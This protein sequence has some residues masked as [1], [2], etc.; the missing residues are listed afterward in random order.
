MSKYVRWQLLLTLLGVILVAALLYTI[1]QGK[2]L[3]VLPTSTPRP[4]PSPA[5]TVV[6]MRGGAY[7]EGVVGYAQLINPLFSLFNDVD[8]D[9]CA[10]I[11]EGLTVVSE[12]GEIE[13]RLAERW[14]V[15]DDGRIYT[16]YLRDDVRW[17]DGEPFTAA[18]VAF[19]IGLLQSPDFPVSH[20]YANLWRSVAV[21][22]VD[23]HTVR[24]VL[25]EPYAPFI[26]Y[27]T[28]GLIPQH[29]LGTVPVA[30]LL[31]HP[32]N[33]APVGT[34]LFRLVELDQAHALLETNPHHSLWRETMLDRVELRFYN[35]DADVLAAYQSGEV[36]GIGR[37]LLQDMDR[38][39]AE[40]D[41]QLYSARQS[42]YGLIFFNLQSVDKPFLQ[43][44]RV[45]QA[46]AYALDR[47]SLIDAA[48][49]GQGAAIYSPIM[50][51]SWA[52]KADV[53]RYDRDLG[54]AASLLDQA[55]YTLPDSTRV[56]VGDV[57]SQQ[58]AVRAK[59]GQLLEFTLLTDTASEHVA[60]ANALATQWAAAGARVLI[61]SVDLSTLAVAHLQPR[62]FDAV[63]LEWAWQLDPDPYPLWHETQIESPGQNYSGFENRDAS[64]AIEV[65]RQLTDR[66]QRK[67]LYDLFQDIFDQEVP[68]IL[69]YQ[70]IYTFGVDKQVRDV[71]ISPLFDPSDRFRNI[72]QW[73]PLEKEVLLRDLNDQV[74]DTLDR[75]LD[76]W[77]DSGR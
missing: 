6:Q 26:D 65:A 72:W 58:A 47:Q 5:V 23:P 64:E 75:Q 31:T 30:G 74:D 50:P 51:Q 71:Q 38:A 10:L 35:T 24:F 28:L 53:E 61:Q 63:L 48:L 3:T 9:L 59:N 57:G 37:I 73:A 42:G 22:V 27:T 46:L 69:L 43:D 7:V 77:Y 8:R 17:Q 29:I 11:F 55:G 67:P 66:S 2:E 45:R 62:R 25:N 68:A 40:P 15:S 13:P 19:T 12:R 32:F 56:R 4:S 36:M 21:E 18:D 1:S 76:L 14:S 41:L 44:R 33:V 49:G 20:A 54:A 16:F 34:G 39:R 70:P 60:L 52:Y